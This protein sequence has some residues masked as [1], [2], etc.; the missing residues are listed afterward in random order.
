MKY[1]IEEDTLGK[2]K[3]PRGA[4]WGA[5]TQRAV[6]N[7]PISGISMNFPFTP[8]FIQVLGKIKD[9][10]LKANNKLKLLPTNKQRAISKAAKEVWQNKHGKQFPIDVFQTREP[11][12]I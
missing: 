11:A 5:Q 3:V 12:L 8:T 2:V 6:D 7:F 10:V 4:L 9:A 1:R